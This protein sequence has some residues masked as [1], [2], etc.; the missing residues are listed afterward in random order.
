MWFKE[1]KGWSGVGGVELL[2]W[3]SCRQPRWLSGGGVAVVVAPVVSTSVDG[4]EGLLYRVSY[5]SGPCGLPI[6]Q[7]GPQ[8]TPMVRGVFWS[9]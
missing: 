6:L 1:R 7:F 3:Q 5:T 2:E 4:C 8:L 9:S